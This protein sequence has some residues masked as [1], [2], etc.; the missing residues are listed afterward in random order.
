MRPA[1]VAL[2]LLAAVP[3]RG[4]GDMPSNMEQFQL[5]LLRRPANAKQYP[6]AELENIQKGHLGHLKKMAQAGK[7][8]VAGPL[9]DQPDKSMR[10]LALYRVGSLE[11]ARKLA[12]DD[13]AVK[14]GRLEVEVMTWWVEKGAMTFP[15]AEKMSSTK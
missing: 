12:A 14:A 5:V 10:G 6:E 11:A 9:D 15:V 8:V 1:L 7:L 2:A 4:A 3:S 13:P